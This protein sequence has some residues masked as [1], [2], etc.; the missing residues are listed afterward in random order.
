M[1]FTMNLE[2]H[3]GDVVRKGA[4]AAGVSDE[5]AAQAA[6]LS[7]PELK[8]FH[9]SGQISK[10][11]NFTALGAKIDLDGAKLERV[12]K[13]WLPAPPDLSQWRELRQITTTG[14][15]MTVNCYFAWDEVSREA[16][17]FDTGW[18]AAPILELIE[19]NKLEL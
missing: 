5:A 9:E 17:L 16:A 6:G 7:L 10:P 11:I 18:Q 3:A 12:A 2:D 13:G 1:P 19:Q 15:G 4:M 14:E 8:S